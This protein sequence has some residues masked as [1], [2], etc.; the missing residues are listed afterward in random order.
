M[1]GL[2]TLTP[3][4]EYRLHLED[5][6]FRLLI[7]SL[8]D[9]RPVSDRGGSDLHSHEFSELFVC[10]SG[11]VT[12]MTESSLLELRDGEAAVVLPGILHRK[13]DVGRRTEWYTLS[14][15]GERRTVRDSGGLYRRLRGFFEGNSI[16]IVRNVPSLAEDM[17][18]IEGEF[19]K[20]DTLQPPLLLVS[21]L[22]HM[23][24]S[25]IV[26]QIPISSDRTPV[27]GE[28]SR[29]MKMDEIIES[30]YTEDWNAEKAAAALH[31][32]SRQVDR[33]ARKRYGKSFHHTLMD[34]RC[35]RAVHLLLTTD[36]PVTGIVTASGFCSAKSLY[37]EFR[38]RCGM[39]PTEFRRRAR[40]AS[41]V[42]D[43]EAPKPYCSDDKQTIAGIGIP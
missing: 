2:T 12:L 25:G 32:S 39:T 14:F 1:T 41:P 5:T 38:Q 42:P 13:A 23:A 10:V 17:R 22:L 8:P 37:R 26:T 7:E 16:L 18:R 21:L 24:D 19:R 9:S 43:F 4:T 11:S 30:H 35:Q 6:D 31:I 33:I 28:I 34:K 29:L 15:S 3:S 27:S 40:E 20:A 36:L